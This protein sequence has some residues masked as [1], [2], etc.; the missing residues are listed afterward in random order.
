MPDDLLVNLAESRG[1]VEALLDSLPSTFAVNSS[2]RRA[3]GC[4]RVKFRVLIYLEPA[5]VSAP[6]RGGMPG[7]VRLGFIAW[8][9][10][11]GNLGVG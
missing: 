3:G 5:Q 2:V 10:R 4:A 9:C 1:V 8:G 6:G 7:A 11:I